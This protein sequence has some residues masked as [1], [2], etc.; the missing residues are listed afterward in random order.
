MVRLKELTLFHIMGCLTFLVMGLVINLLQLSFYLLLFKINKR[1]FRRINY[2]L[3]Y[4]LYGY[5]LFIA[6]WWSG[7]TMTIICDEEFRSRIAKKDPEENGLILMNHH[8][9]LDWLYAWMVADRVGVVG[10]CRS[11]IKDSLKYL[12]IL[13]W[14]GN[15]SDDLYLKRNMEKDK[16]K[17]QNNLKE[18]LEYPYPVWLFLFAEG[19]RF[20]SEKHQ[21]SQKFAESKGLPRLEHH[22]IPRT[23]G[24]T[25][26]IPKLDKTK[27]TTMY[28][29]T[30]V[31]GTGDSAP[32]TLTSLILGRKTE[33]TVVIRKIN[34]ENIPTGEEEGA[35]WLMDIYVE[36]DKIKKSLLEGTWQILNESHTITT[37]TLS[38]VCNP[39]RMQS[40]LLTVSVNI[41]V[42][43][44]L[45]YLLLSGGIVTWAVAVLVLIM[46][47]A[48]LHVLVNASKVKKSAKAD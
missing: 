19:T 42:L 12:P 6:E 43:L 11:F 47:W 25:F 27:I 34:L 48:A 8:Y 22:L 26:T 44:P 20:T 21:A 30:M 37:S 1:L 9:E 28:D 46:S 41:L 33:A 24:F 18:L 29:L 10:N 39:P 13:G 4:G 31:A 16:E 32:P 14:A 40:C 35:K 23:K 15:F 2:Y 38:S 7:S 45:F 3:M 5:L 36:K 17:I